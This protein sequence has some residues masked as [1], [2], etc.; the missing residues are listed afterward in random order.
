[1]PDVLVLAIGLAVLVVGGEVLV[2]GATATAAAAGLSPMIIGLTLVG[3]GTSSPELVTSLTAAY[4]GAPDII[5]GNV[6]GSN[7]ANVLLI[8]ATAAL[9]SPLAVEPRS[10]KREGSM[11]AFA[12][13][14]A[15]VLTLVGGV[16]RIT[17]L[18]MLVLLIAYLVYVVRVERAQ[19]D[20]E[21][22]AAELLV[23]D[24]PSVSTGIWGG[25]ALTV[26]G[27][28]LTIGGARFMIDGAIGIA[29]TIGISDVVI[30]LTIVA[31]GTSAPELVT[32]IIAALKGH[33]EVALGNVIGSNL[34]NILFIFGTT[35]VVTPFDIPSTLASRDIWVMAGATLLMLVVAR[36]GFK[37]HRW[38]GALML[39]LYI[40]YVSWLVATAL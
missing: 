27:I 13:L 23:E 1:M 30:G 21:G 19:P 6:V 28:G 32:S 33:A 24:L 11:V 18:A 35:A 9:I 31:L 14:I 3:F 5:A 20:A 22:A 15:V 40:G 8:L 10:F 4:Q 25:I 39:T 37:I 7:T 29:E 38:E 16:G 17:G 26:V 36:N 2:R 34:F 12:T